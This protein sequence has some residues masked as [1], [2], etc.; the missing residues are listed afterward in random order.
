MFVG[1]DQEEI[2]LYGSRYFV[3][4]PPAPMER[5]ALFLTADMIGRALGGVCESCVFV[6]GSEHSPG[7]RPWIERA[8]RDRPRSPHGFVLFRQANRAGLILPG[9]KGDRIDAISTRSRVCGQRR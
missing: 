7:L 9:R 8:A 1:F 5:L 4:H 3:E 6:M 2:G